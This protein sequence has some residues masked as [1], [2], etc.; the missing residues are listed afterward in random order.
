MTHEVLPDRLTTYVNQAHNIY[1]KTSP[2]SELGV[3]YIATM[4]LMLHWC[5][6]LKCY[7]EIYEFSILVFLG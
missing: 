5:F 6:S 3:I 1:I 2:K 7:W 4:S